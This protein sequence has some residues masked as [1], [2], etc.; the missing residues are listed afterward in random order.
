VFNGSSFSLS[1]NCSSASYCSVDW[2]RV[3]VLW[4]GVL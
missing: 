4:F 1:L 3:F 2:E